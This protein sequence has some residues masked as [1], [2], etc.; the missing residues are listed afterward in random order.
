MLTCVS[1]RLSLCL[2][3]R[4]LSRDHEGA[5]GLRN[6]KRESAE[7][8]L[9]LTIS[10][11]KKPRLD[12]KVRDPASAIGGPSGPLLSSGSATS[13][14]FGQDFS[15]AFDFMSGE[16][17]S[18]PLHNIFHEDRS[19]PVTDV[20]QERAIKLER[21]LVADSPDPG[22]GFSPSHD[23]EGPS[24]PLNQTKSD[25]FNF[26][27]SFPTT[28]PESLFLDEDHTDD[29]TI[30]KQVS[31]HLLFAT[32]FPI[33][34]S[35]L[36][37]Q[38]LNERAVVLCGVGKSRNK[39]DR[40]VKK[41]TVDIEHYFRLLPGIS[42]PILP[43]SKLQDLM[44]RFQALP[45][46]EQRN[47]AMTCVKS[48]RSSL[49]IAGKGSGTKLSHYPACAQLVFVCELLEISGGIQQILDLLVDI[50]ACDRAKEKV[51]GLEV[52]RPQ[53]PLPAELCLPVVWLLQKYFSC[54]LLSQQDTTTVFEG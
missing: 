28:A 40:I 41:I 21:L 11:P 8:E 18:S 19:A 51:E 16:D 13:A 5:S 4:V 48:L 42:T 1:A 23:G 17:S 14:S 6:M 43:D 46:F 7:P 30:N 35:R 33:C 32:Y 27:L 44:H 37:K 53:P 50:I 29:V 36:T 22:L 2:L 47:L 49:H 31:R 26:A 45:T 54:L 10:L 3:C 25:P 52:H 38:E 34:G 12:P 20:L 24:S 39:V 9:S 15:S